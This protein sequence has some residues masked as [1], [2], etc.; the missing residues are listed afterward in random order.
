[1]KNT[2]FP[3]LSIILFVSIF[4]CSDF[5]SKSNNRNINV[6]INETKEEYEFS[7]S[8]E[9]NK[10]RRVQ[11]YINQQIR[12]NALFTSVDDDL[13][14][15]TLLNDRTKFYIKSS[16]GKLKIIINKIENSQ[17]SIARIK[18]MC[19]GVKSIVAKN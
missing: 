19:E 12:P 17:A 18:T 4:S 3:T 15:T 10:T 14:V 11:K 1:M 9:I 16:A 5:G 8:Y 6:Y 13:N 7:T 2:V